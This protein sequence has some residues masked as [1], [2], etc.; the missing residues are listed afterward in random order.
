MRV[1]VVLFVLV[2]VSACTSAGEEAT[3]SVTVPTSAAWSQV[4]DDAAVFGGE[5]DQV[6]WDVTVGGPGLVA[7]GMDGFGRDADAVVWTSVDGINWVRLPDDEAVLGGEP[8]ISVLQGVTV[9]GPGLVAVG[10]YGFPGDVDA[11]VWTSAD[12]TSWVRVPHDDTVFGGTSPQWMLDVTV[13][14]PG[15]VAV[16]SDYRDAAVW[17]SVD[18]IKWVRVPHDEAVFGGEG[19]QEIEHVAAGG[20]GLVAVGYDESNDSS[21]GAVWTS[22]DGTSWSRIPDDE[23]VFGGEGFQGLSSV[24]AGGPGLVAVGTDGPDDNEDAAVWTSADGI[25]WTQAPHDDSAFGG[26]GE[27]SMWDVTLGG[28]GLVAVGWDGTDTGDTGVG[29]AAVWTSKDG[30]TWVRVPHDATV[31]GGEGDQIMWSL[32]TGGPGLVGVGWDESGGDLDAAVWTTED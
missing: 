18:G 10:S 1:L 29:D 17:T 14:G 7:V 20:P 5:G 8:S 22:P 28:P 3:T 25:T 21:D 32:T 12:G 23:A 24:V 31:F 15:L 16:G 2:L 19:V 26:D 13:G 30:I 11:A 4:P 27:Q 6:M 9:G